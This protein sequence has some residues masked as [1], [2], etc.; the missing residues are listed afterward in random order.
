MRKDLFK[1]DYE[2]T[3]LNIS[4]FV[5]NIVIIALLSWWVTIVDSYQ[6]LIIGLIITFLLRP[7]FIN[8]MIEM[9]KKIEI[10]KEVFT[11]TNL[12][13]YGKR[14]RYQT[15]K[16]KKIVKVVKSNG[17]L[18]VI[19]LVFITGEKVVIHEDS[20]FNGTNYY[21]L[22]YYLNQNFPY[23]PVKL[24]DYYV[25]FFMGLDKDDID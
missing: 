17:E 4:E 1:D 7:K 22:N 12:F 3:I 13:G 5:F 8:R 10:N 19:I 25:N 20:R 15:D 24:K 21:V 9:S 11:V 14:K 23:I 2:I 6:G 16:L 18:K